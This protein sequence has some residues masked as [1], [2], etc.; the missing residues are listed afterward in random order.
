MSQNWEIIKQLTITDFKLRYS[1]SVLGYLWSLLKPLIFFAVLYTVFGKMLKLGGNID[2]FASYLLIGIMFWSF[3]SE[4]TTNGMQAVVGKGYLIKKIYF[5]RLI[6]VLVA[7]L[8]ALIN[9]GLNLIVLLGF[10]LYFH[11]NVLQ[12]R[13][14]LLFPY[15]IELWLFSF[16]V[17]LILAVLYVRWRDLSYIWELWLQITFYLTPIIFALSL[18]P[19]K[20][21]P[22]VMLNPVAQIIIDCRALFINFSFTPVWYYPWPQFLI[23]LAVLIAGLTIFQ[24]QQ[25]YFAEQI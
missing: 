14:L 4:A 9:L 5:P 24:Q 13:T 21:L 18:I 1:G 20:F 15:I 23:V 11:I 8:N 7:S 12:W 3:L 22:W 16:G 2:N 6:V 25:K 10:L 19:A 17:A